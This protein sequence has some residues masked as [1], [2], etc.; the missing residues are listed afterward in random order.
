MEDTPNCNR[1]EAAVGVGE[2]WAI[3]ALVVGV[4]AVVASAERV[5]GFKGSKGLV[6]VF[7]LG[8]LFRMET[9][10][11]RDVDARDED[12]DLGVRRLGVLPFG[13]W[14]PEDVA[15]MSVLRS[16]DT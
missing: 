5:K 12:D 13:V 11:D 10:L 3:E 1:L 6:E 8:R 16:N 14:S 15:S 7:G 9:G 2:N 4:R